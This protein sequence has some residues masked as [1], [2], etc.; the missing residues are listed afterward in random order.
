VCGLLSVNMV[1]LRFVR[2]VGVCQESCPF[3]CSVMPTLDALQCVTLLPV[4]RL[5]C[6]Q[7][8]AIVNEAA[9]II[10]V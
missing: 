1:I 8:G 7:F 4:D 2:I 3:C 6:L 9:A 5:C 10:S